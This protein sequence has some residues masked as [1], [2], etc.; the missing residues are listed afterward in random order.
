MKEDRQMSRPKPTLLVKTRETRDYD[1]VRV[2][3]RIL[4]TSTGDAVDKIVFQG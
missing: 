3:V 1:L 2:M 4:V